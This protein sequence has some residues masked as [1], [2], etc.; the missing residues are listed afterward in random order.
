MPI[1]Q[2]EATGLSYYH[3]RLEKEMHFVDDPAPITD[4]QTTSDGSRN[5]HYVPTNTEQF[6]AQIQIVTQERGAIYGEAHVNFGRMGLCNMV[7][8]DCEDQAIKA[9]LHM[10]MYKVC[11]LVQSPLHLDSVVDIAG[12]AR[13]IAQIQDSRNGR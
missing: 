10:I 2:D 12:Y 1:T 13:C 6:D 8:E 11:R 5:P 7:V 3:K 4:Y 9:A